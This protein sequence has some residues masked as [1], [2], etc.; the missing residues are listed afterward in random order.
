MEYPCFSDDEFYRRHQEVRARMAA[1]NVEVLVMFG[2]GRSPN[3]HYLSNWLSTREAHLIFPAVGEGTLFIQLSNHVETAARMAILND[4]R[5]GGRSAS[6]LPSSIERVTEELIARG[7]GETR[8]GIVGPLPFQQYSYLRDHMEHADFVEFTHVLNQLRQRKSAEEIERIREASELAD[9]SIVALKEQ[10]RPGLTGYDI[11]KI[12]EDSYLS[13]G[14]TNGIH[15]F[16]CTAMSDPNICIPSQYPTSRTVELGD[17]C[18]LEISV[19]LFGYS[20]QVLRTF[21]VG[22][23]PSPL[24]AELFEVARDTFE[25]IR[26]VLRAGATVADV[27]AVSDVIDSR[28][29]SLGDDLLH[30]AGQ[31]PPIVRTRQTSSGQNEGFRFEE[32]MCVVIQP[33]VINKERTA[34]VQYGEMV[35]ITGAGNRRLHA[36]E[37]GLL[38]CP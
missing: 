37:E 15:Y 19:D 23:G 20:G 9:L 5:F 6:G 25:G 2:S 8:I 16:L 7:Y 34:G 31:L 29:F 36:A 18:V 26:A 33:N 21:V 10:L 32:D 38:V 24:Y 28:G 12:L 3:I 14:G 27:V 13:K 30:G 4:V 11:V 1:N 35:H 22:E 17:V